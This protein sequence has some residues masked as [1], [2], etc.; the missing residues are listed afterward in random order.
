MVLNDVQYLVLSS[1]R[2]YL[3]D[4]F[5]VTRCV[6]IAGIRWRCCSAVEC[7]TRS[8]ANQGPY[9][10]PKK[11]RACPDAISLQFVH[12][13]SRRSCINELTDSMRFPAT[14][15]RP[16][17]LE[18][19]TICLRVA[20]RR[21]EPCSSGMTDCWRVDVDGEVVGECRNGVRRSITLYMGEDDDE[22]R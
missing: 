11:M 16:G 18:L 22:R 2:V 19:Y 20:S 14:H 21:P 7:S 8:H 9:C 4:V 5:E 15:E 17:L 6:S 12:A 1:F 10:H 13:V 3:R